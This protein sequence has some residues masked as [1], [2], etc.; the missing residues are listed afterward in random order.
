MPPVDLRD[1]T[2]LHNRNFV[3]FDDTQDIVG[4]V[5]PN[6]NEFEEIHTIIIIFLMFILATSSVSISAFLTYFVDVYLINGWVAAS[7]R[8]RLE[9]MTRVKEGFML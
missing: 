5:F 4:S 7:C 6:G 3:I 8:T 1:P 2:A 9:K